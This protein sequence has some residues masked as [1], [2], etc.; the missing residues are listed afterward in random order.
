[1]Y[2]EV[3]ENKLYFLDEILLKKVGRFLPRELS[4]QAI[5]KRK[6]IQDLSY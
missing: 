3:N 2:S 5:I 6:N 1:M 4:I